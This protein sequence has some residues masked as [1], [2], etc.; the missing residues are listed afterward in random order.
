MKT[1]TSLNR[2]SMSRSLPLITSH[3]SLLTIFLLLAWFALS[4]AVQAVTPAP[5][6]GY[7]GANTAEGTQALF[8]LTSGIDDTAL[9]YQALFHNTTGNSNTAEGF[10]ALFNNTTGFQ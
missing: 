5:D 4:S 3:Y 8:S 9:G 2:S 1:T 10:R 7:T 6:G